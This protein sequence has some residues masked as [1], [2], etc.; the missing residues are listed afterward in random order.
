MAPA[1]A[2]LPV[3]DLPNEVFFMGELLHRLRGMPWGYVLPVGNLYGQINVSNLS[4]YLAPDVKVGKVRGFN[5][6]SLLHEKMIDRSGLAHIPHL[7]S[8]L[9]A[10]EL[11]VLPEGMRMS[12]EEELWTRY[13]QYPS[14]IGIESAQ[15]LSWAFSAVRVGTGGFVPYFTP[16]EMLV[17]VKALQG[18]GVINR[19]QAEEMAISEG[20]LSKVVSCINGKMGYMNIA[21]MPNNSG[22]YGRRSCYALNEDS[23]YD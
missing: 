4:P 8:Q 11:I 19:A 20:N 9:L 3:P 1:E 13:F 10:E 18:G 12:N 6:L 16:T 5:S 23:K 2:L 22:A 15:N 7:L 14:N 21:L 17:L